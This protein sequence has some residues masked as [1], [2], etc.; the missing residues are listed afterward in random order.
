MPSK[1]RAKTANAPKSSKTRRSELYHPIRIV[2]LHPGKAKAAAP[3]F[4][5]QLAYRN[6]PLLT[7]AQVFTI[8]WGAAWNEAP[9]NSLLSRVNQ[10]FDFILTSQL[11]DQ[12][13]EYS[14]SGQQIGHGAR[15]GSITLTSPD[16]GTT[17]DDSA[18]QA[19]LQQQIS[20]G[21]LPAATANT[22][23]RFPS[24]RSHRYAGWRRVLSSFL[25]VSR[26]HQP[27]HLLRRDAV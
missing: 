1:P 12:L 3:Q 7:P 20:S 17:V 8:F 25:R 10:F 26:R 27:Q 24:A 5:P 19:L 21:T 11:L 4:S 15:L 14:V 23:Y 2:P 9:Q 6:G 16:P 18:I 22:L 13:A